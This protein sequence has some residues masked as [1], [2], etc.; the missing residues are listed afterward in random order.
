MR[1]FELRGV[2]GM[3]LSALTE[4][5]MEEEL[6]LTNK[7]LQEINKNRKKQFLASPLYIVALYWKYVRAL[8]SLRMCAAHAAVPRGPGDARPGTNSEKSIPY[9]VSYIQ[10]LYRGPFI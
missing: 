1:L 3:A 7:S 2:D 6:A 5:S 8:T 9:D 4:M 10:P